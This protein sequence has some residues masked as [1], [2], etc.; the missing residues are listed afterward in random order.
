M[1]GVGTVSENTFGTSGSSQ[2]SDQ[3]WE[4]IF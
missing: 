4:G 1:H 2:S 3:T